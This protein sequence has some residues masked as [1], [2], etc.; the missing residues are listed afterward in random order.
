MINWLYFR[1]MS[2]NH[3]TPVR[4]RAKSPRANGKMSSSAAKRVR[5]ASPKSTTARK[6]VRA[7]KDADQ[8]DSPSNDEEIARR[9]LY[10]PSDIQLVVS[11]HVSE[12]SRQLYLNVAI[13]AATLILLLTFSMLTARPSEC[14][15][16]NS[17]VRP[18]ASDV[19]NRRESQQ[20]PNALSLNGNSNIRLATSSALPPPLDSR[21][22]SLSRTTLKYA[23]DEGNPVLGNCWW[24]PPPSGSGTVTFEFMECITPASLVVHNIGPVD[25]YPSKVSWWSDTNLLGEI[26]VKGGKQT[27]HVPR[28]KKACYKN[29]TIFVSGRGS[30]NGSCTH[31]IGIV[32]GNPHHRPLQV[33]EVGGGGNPSSKQ[34]HTSDSASG[35]QLDNHPAANITP[36][37]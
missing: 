9:I 19:I 13:I 1:K 37:T 10:R 24:L 16:N 34:D 26:M 30:V 17:L 28:N 35:R 25:L 21:A 22:V 3:K 36:R 14:D 32:P 27:V 23:F 2:N 6:Q 4:Q 20:P 29:L 12:S 5:S 7:R 15:D 18:V 33:T 8:A 31:R 11:K